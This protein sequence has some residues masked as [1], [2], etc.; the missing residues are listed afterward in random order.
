MLCIGSKPYPGVSNQ[1]V[2]LRVPCGY[3]MEKPTGC[4]DVV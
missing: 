2:I 3:K 4:S 1:D